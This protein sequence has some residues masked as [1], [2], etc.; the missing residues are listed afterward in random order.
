MTGHGMRPDRFETRF[1]GTRFDI[2]GT[3]Q[4]YPSTAKWH[5]KAV[6]D[7]FDDDGVV[8]RTWAQPV[9]DVDNIDNASCANSE[10]QQGD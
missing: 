8:M 1:T 9:I 6:C 10:N 4:F 3:T 7:S 5:S 2:A